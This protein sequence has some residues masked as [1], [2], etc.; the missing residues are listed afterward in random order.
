MTKK[1]D[2]IYPFFFLHNWK[3][4]HE[5]DVCVC[6]K[7]CFLKLKLFVHHGISLILIYVFVFLLFYL[8]LGQN[9]MLDWLDLFWMKKKFFSLDINEQ[10]K[11]KWDSILCEAIFRL[12]RLDLRSNGNNNNNFFF[13]FQIIIII[14]ILN[15][16]R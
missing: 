4:I 12:Y 16:D 11:K 2:R 14:I 15:I 7:Y 6:V 10:E 8:F 13:C 3:R 1:M 9:L 5:L